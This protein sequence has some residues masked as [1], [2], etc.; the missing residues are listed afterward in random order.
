MAEVAAQKV[1]SPRLKKMHG[2]QSLDA[3]IL[4]PLGAEEERREKSN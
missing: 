4:S 3:P 1:Y 2:F